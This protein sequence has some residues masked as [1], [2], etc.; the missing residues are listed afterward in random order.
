MLANS[1]VILQREGPE[2]LSCTTSRQPDRV[3]MQEHSGESLGCG[4]EWPEAVSRPCQVPLQ[5]PLTT[6]LCASFLPN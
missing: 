5:R 4:P 1:Q 6:P 3:Q 2:V